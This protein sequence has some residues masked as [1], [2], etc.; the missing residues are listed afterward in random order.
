MTELLQTFVLAETKGQ[1]CWFDKASTVKLM[2]HCFHIQSNKLLWFLLIYYIWI[3]TEF[4]SST[5]LFTGIKTHTSQKKPYAVEHMKHPDSSSS[6]APSSALP[7]NVPFPSPV[8]HHSTLS[9]TISSFDIYPAQ[10]RQFLPQRKG[11]NKIILFL[12]CSII[13]SSFLVAEVSH[14]CSH[15]MHSLFS[16][17]NSSPFLSNLLCSPRSF[18]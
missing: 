15:S 6:Q 4:T 13:A 5:G 3:H 11:Q 9:Q 17:S 8:F 7:A 12:F 16:I 1:I 14:V 2:K 10:E 18:T